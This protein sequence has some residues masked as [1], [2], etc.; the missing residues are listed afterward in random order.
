MRFKKSFVLATAAGLALSV[1]A[2]CSGGS[3]KAVPTTTTSTTLAIALPADQVSMQGRGT[4]TLDE[5]GVGWTLDPTK[6]NDI[7][8][9]SETGGICNGPNLK[10]RMLGNIG[11]SAYNYVSNPEIG[12]KFSIVTHV[13]PTV[14]ASKAAF[15]RTSASYACNIWSESESRSE[16]SISILPNF[17][18]GD[19]SIARRRTIS[20]PIVD[21]PICISGIDFRIQDILEVRIGAQIFR[22]D[23]TKNAPRGEVDIN[24][25]IDDVQPGVVPPDTAQLFRLAQQAIDKYNA[26][27]K[28]YT[29]EVYAA[30]ATTTSTTKPKKDSSK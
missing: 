8:P 3:E 15:A 19:E 4:L 2:G 27:L 9:A 7:G 30:L 21:V 20:Y 12:P 29:K 11:S 23:L 16:N 18:S 25:C 17:P 28:Q 6:V 1:V 22:F 26:E 5:L 13:F 14:D 24:A 10:A